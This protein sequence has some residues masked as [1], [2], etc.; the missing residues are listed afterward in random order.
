MFEIDKARCVTISEKLLWNIWQ[1]QKI[2]NS[3]STRENMSEQKPYTCKTCGQT[4]ENAGKYL[5]DQKK[6]KKELTRC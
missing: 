1:E 4:F 6:H 2:S 5:A 3:C